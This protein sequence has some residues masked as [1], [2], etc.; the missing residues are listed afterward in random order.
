[1]IR[2]QHIVVSLIILLSLAMLYCVTDTALR[3]ETRKLSREYNFKFI[4]YDENIENPESD[5]RAFYK[6]YIDKLE[7]GRTTIGLESQMKTFSSTISNNR[8]LLVVEKWVLDEK[9]MKYVKLN[10]IDQP[11]PNFLY[12][13]LPYDSVAV[14]TLKNDTVERRAFF[15]IELQ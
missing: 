9:K 2:K 4:G 8:H 3:D 6:I 10:N 5:R 13:N 15:D 12:F 7:T 1:M 11:K 14:I